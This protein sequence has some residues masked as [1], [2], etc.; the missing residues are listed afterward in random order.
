MSETPDTAFDINKI[1]VDLAQKIITESAG[2]VLSKSKGFFKGL[3]NAFRLRLESSYKNYLTCVYERYSKAKSFLIRDESTQLSDFY[4]PQGI[5]CG[6]KKLGKPQFSTS[7]LK[8][9][10]L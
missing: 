5:S 7:A 1:T 4:V 9:I 2:N 10:S 3:N 8:T 6:G